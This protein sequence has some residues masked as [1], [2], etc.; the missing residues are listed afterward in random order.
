MTALGQDNQND[1]IR[2]RCASVVKW[3]FAV[4]GSRVLRARSFAPLKSAG[5]QDDGFIS[6]MAALFPGWRLIY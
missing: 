4:V 3:F 1:G 5:H 6:R 2:F